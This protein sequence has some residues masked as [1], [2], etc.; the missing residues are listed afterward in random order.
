MKFLGRL[1]A[2]L[3]QLLTDP[4]TSAMQAAADKDMIGR[5]G[6]DI[7][8]K[9]LQSRGC[10][11]LYRNFK[12]PHGGEIDI[13]CRHEKVLAFVEV[14]TRTSIAFGRPAQAVT[15]DKRA[16]ILRGAAAWLRMLDEKEI[17]FRFDIVEVL[18]I[19]GLRPDVNWLQGAFS[20][21]GVA[22]YARTEE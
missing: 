7:A 17:P 5:R 14:K 12:G 2:R 10:R 18:L 20:S 4:W 16:L 21:K 13:T 8:A 19:P 9:W 1:I 6:E 22:D 15:E 11:V 3:S